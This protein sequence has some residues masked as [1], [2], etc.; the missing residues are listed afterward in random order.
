MWNIDIKPQSPLSFF[1]H[2]FF[3]VCGNVQ[4]WT[5]ST[6]DRADLM[7]DAFT[8]AGAG[9]VSFDVPLSMA[10]YLSQETKYVPWNLAISS[11]IGYISKMMLETPEYVLWKVRPEMVYKCDKALQFFFLF[12]Q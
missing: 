2:F 6:S 10:S 1:Y 7:V 9:M 4:D 12:K 8:F 5:L 11:G 3:F